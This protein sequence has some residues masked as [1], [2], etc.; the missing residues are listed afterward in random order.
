[1]VKYKK[2]QKGSNVLK[3]K[4]VIFD[5]DGTLANTLSDLANAVNYGIEK[6]GLEL[7]NLEEYKIF[8]GDGTD[9]M[10]ERALKENATK[11][12]WRRIK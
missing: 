5:L 8:V 10:I 7:P 11:E 3:F 6:L 1:M 2:S 9:K 12:K 4:G